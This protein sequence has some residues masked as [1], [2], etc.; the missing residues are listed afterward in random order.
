MYFIDG[1]TN[2]LAFDIGRDLESITVLC[3]TLFIFTL[4]NMRMSFEIVAL[5]LLLHENIVFPSQH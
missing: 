4:H 3:S 2:R 5:K 1:I